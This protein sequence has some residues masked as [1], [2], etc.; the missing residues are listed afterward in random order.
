METKLK[1]KIKASGL[2]QSFIAENAKISK[3]ALSLIVNGKSLPTLT[4]AI[5]IARV[6]DETVENL[7]GD[8]VE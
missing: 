4:A 3:S 1:S 8:L 7:W 2:K 6:L 5:R